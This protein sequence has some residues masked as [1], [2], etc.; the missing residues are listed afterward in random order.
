V[1][2]KGI[3][4]KKQSQVNQAQR[5]VQ[6]MAV[7]AKTRRMLIE[8]A[9]AGKQNISKRSNG[10]RA[11]ETIELLN[12]T[13]ELRRDQLNQKR[14][15]ST[16]SAWV[17]NLH[18]VPGPL[19]RSFW[20]KMYRRRQ[21]I[22]LRP[23]FASL[24]NDLQ[25][26]VKERHSSRGM[27]TETIESEL[28]L[29]EQKFLL[30]MHPVSGESTSL[31]PSSTCWAEPGKD[32]VTLLVCVTSY[33][34]VPHVC[35]CLCIGWH[36]DLDVPMVD[37]SNGILPRS[38][39]FPLLQR[40]LCELYSAP[41]RQAASM[42]RRTH[43]RSLEAPLSAIATATSLAECNPSMLIS[44]KGMYLE[45]PSMLFLVFLSHAIPCIATPR[46]RIQDT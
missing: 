1:E 8:E 46:F 37:K 26:F 33:V 12:T 27:S 40:N 14:N 4:Q 39:V 24:M 44:P 45:F 6:R 41:G 22:V 42:L 31:S 34:G 19:K 5:A 10:N 17:H 28:I 38:V 15:S 16:S 25:S 20:Y 2:A 18:G 3:A 36:L 7:D 21:Q 9:R 35:L 13:A 29:A 32:S 23:T 43:L 30:A 11:N